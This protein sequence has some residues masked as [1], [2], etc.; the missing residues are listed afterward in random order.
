MPRQKKDA[1]ILT[2]K[3]DRHLHEL[4]EQTAKAE[5]KTKTELIEEVLCKR[6]I[7]ADSKGKK[8]LRES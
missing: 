3:L 5:G 6:L 4:L 1:R 8:S 2:I 7:N